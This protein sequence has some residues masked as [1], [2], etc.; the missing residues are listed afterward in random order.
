MMFPLF[1]R[2][3]YAAT[4]VMSSHH[5]STKEASYPHDSQ[6]K[7]RQSKYTGGSSGLQSGNKKSRN[8]Q[9]PLSIPNDTAWGSDEAIVTMKNSTNTTVQDKTSET[10][11]AAAYELDD[12]DFVRDRNTNGGVENGHEQGL[13]AIMMTR[14]WN[15]K[16]THEQ[17][18][19]CSRDA[20]MGYT[21]PD[22]WRG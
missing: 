3:F 2:W 22:G 13:G 17:G 10:T 16:E 7:K 18:S 4:G 11:L 9:H 14:E 15:I 8:F 20:R 12:L 5:Q 6:T 1:K 19:S 21:E